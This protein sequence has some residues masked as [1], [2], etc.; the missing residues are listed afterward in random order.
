MRTGTGSMSVTK[1]IQKTS[2]RPRKRKY[3]MANADSIEI[4]ILPTAMTIA[5]I[6][7]LKSSVPIF[8]LCQAAT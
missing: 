6:A 8:D 4:E 7:E 2:W 1:I 3:T 5:T